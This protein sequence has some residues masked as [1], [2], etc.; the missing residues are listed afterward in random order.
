MSSPLRILVLIGLPDGNRVDIEGIQGDELKFAFTGNLMLL[1]YLDC[2]GLQ[3]MRLQIG[4]VRKRID[5]L[6]A[7]DLVFNAVC[8]ADLNSRA[9]AQARRIVDRLGVPVLNP[10]EAVHRSARDRA[11]ELLAQE[12]ALQ[13]PTTLRIRPQRLRDI[14]A[15]L[16]SGRMGFPFI[17]RPAGGHNGQNMLLVERAEDL[18]RLERFAFDGSDYY[19]I[20]FVDYR[21][22]DGWYRKYRFLVID[23]R[24]YPRHVVADRHWNVHAPARFKTMVNHPELLEQEQAFLDDFEARLGPDS[25]RALGDLNRRLG[26]DYL[27]VDCSLRPDGRL[28]VFETNACINAF[29]AQR[30]ETGRM[31]YLQPHVDRIAAAARGLVFKRAM[32]DAR[33]QPSP[34]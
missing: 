1:R 32:R 22:E 21:D 20:A 8:D 27:G 29:G 2:T 5:R 25:L 12:P 31:S 24:V 33:R 9:L 28:L 7:V 3:A 19:L 15:V 23:G 4:G 26:L 13:V 14:E 30:A 34:A 18:W 11:A 10:P 6:P 17:M 16:A